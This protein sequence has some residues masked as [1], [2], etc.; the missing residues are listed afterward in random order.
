MPCGYLEASLSKGLEKSGYLAEAMP[1]REDCPSISAN[2][3]AAQQNGGHIS[4]MRAMRRS[5]PCVG[6]EWLAVLEDRLQHGYAH[7]EVQSSTATNANRFEL[8]RAHQPAFRVRRTRRS[9]FSCARGGLNRT[10]SC[11]GTLVGVPVDITAAEHP[12]AARLAR[13]DS[14]PTIGTAKAD[15][16]AVQQVKAKAIATLQRLFF[17][18]MVKPGQDA[19]GAAAHALLRL[20]EAVTAGVPEFCTEA[21]DEPLTRS[22]SEALVACRSPPLLQSA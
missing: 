14:V 2:L 21:N 18:E 11:G 4:T 1:V 12:T 9:D 16:E 3:T 5:K 6:A 17:E 7:T 19:N 10:S 22:T 13:C 15:E 20:G 8:R